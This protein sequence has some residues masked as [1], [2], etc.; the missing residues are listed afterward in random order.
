MHFDLTT[1]D[2]ED[3]ILKDCLF[4]GEDCVWVFPAKQ[5]LKWT[6]DTIKLRSSIWRKKDGKLIS[7]GFKKFFNWEESP[8]IYP[9]PTDTKG[10]TFFEKLDGSCLIVSK[11]NGQLIVRTRRTTVDV[12]LNS[13]EIDVLKQK[14]PKA[15]EFG[16][17]ETA[18]YSLLF[19]WLSPAN[20]IVIQHPEPDMKLLTIVSHVDYSYW[21]QLQV[22]EHAKLL[23]VGR[24]QRL[25]LPELTDIVEKVAAWKDIEGGC[26][27][28]GKDQHIRKVKS[29]WYTSLHAFKG[30]LTYEN[31]VD[32]YLA[33]NART[34]EEFNSFIFETFGYEGHKLAIPLISQLLD[35][36]KNVDGIL[37]GMR[38]FLTTQ[39]VGLTRK[40]IAEKVYS[41]YGY[42]NRA[43]AVFSI[44]D[45]KPLS[46]KLHKKF[47]IQSQFSK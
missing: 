5:G 38:N 14:Y 29:E 40:D 27:Y 43:S 22:D 9:A 23:E 15:F 25:E 30:Q 20:C 24:P 32:V 7:A 37:A 19:E 1:I 46:N 39:C 34:F 44:L 3:F 33:N 47:L 13:Y 36:Q 16:G 6:T 42:T 28:Y 26:C 18:D 11:Y 21:T 12:H 10:V 8:H 4:G 35:A 31:L 2:T 17:L 45:N 41:S